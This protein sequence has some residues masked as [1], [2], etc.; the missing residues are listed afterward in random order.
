MITLC[1]DTRTRAHTHPCCP[2]ASLAPM[3][4]R[5]HS[6]S[7]SLPF[8]PGRSRVRP[9]VPSAGV[10]TNPGGA[11]GPV[12]GGMQAQHCLGPA[13]RR[14]DAKPTLGSVP[15]LPPPS[16]SQDAGAEGYPW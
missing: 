15:V 11:Q 6:A 10:A 12:P 8:S 5:D 2:P 9:A 7:G 13:S 16:V 14:E 4:P 1:S 3:T